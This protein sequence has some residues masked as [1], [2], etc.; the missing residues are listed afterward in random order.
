[1][2]VAWGKDECSS[3]EYMSFLTSLFMLLLMVKYESYSGAR[4]HLVGGSVLEE[5]EEEKLYW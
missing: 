5:E 3:S 4:L 2:G 1:M